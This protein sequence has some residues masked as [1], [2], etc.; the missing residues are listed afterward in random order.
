M[1]KLFYKN[2]TERNILRVYFDQSFFQKQAF[3]LLLNQALSA[4]FN[5]T[6]F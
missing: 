5:Q 3:A 4:H 1:I 6:F 2:S